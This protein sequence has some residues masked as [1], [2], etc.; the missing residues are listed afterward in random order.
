MIESHSTTGTAGIAARQA[1]R[2]A[3]IKKGLVI[4]NTGHGKGKTTAALGLLLRAWGR[5]MRVCVIQF[6]K[7]EKAQFGEHKA[8]KKLGIEFISSGDGFTWLSK[9]LDESVARARH[10]WEIAQ[11]KITNG[12]YDVIILDEMT[13]CFKYGWLDFVDVRAWLIEH[14][15][16]MLHLVITG[17]Y[18]PD[19]LIE[20]AD[21]VTEM[22]L[23]KH[24]FKEQSIRAQAGIEF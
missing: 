14:K 8:A 13:Y 21:L 23:I 17:R 12:D 19:E 4:V 7:N 20:Y 22:K 11:Q 1:A 24:P 3:N 9:D 6:I 18:A 10:G 5:N 16:P 15:P 2:K